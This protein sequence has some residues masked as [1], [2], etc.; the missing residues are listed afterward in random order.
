MRRHLLALIFSLAVSPA[1]A[2]GAAT[3]AAPCNALCMQR[4]QDSHALAA[5]GQYKE[6]LDTLEVARKD[7]P[8][9]S[10]PLSTA[11]FMLRD[12][13]TRVPPEQVDEL[14]KKARGLA[15]RAL[16]LDPDDALAQEAL[17]HLDNEGFSALRQLTPAATKAWEEAERFFTER[18]YAEALA[19]FRE[20][21][22]LD[23]ASSLPLIGAGDCYFAQQQW[24][25]AERLFRAAVEREP[26][27]AQAWR[28]LSD[29][30]AQQGKLKAAE[31]ALLSGI[32]ADPG[33]LPNWTKLARLRAAAGLPLKPLRFRRG[34]NLVFDKKGDV[35]I[36]VEQEIANQSGTPDG[37]FRMTLALSEASARVA[38]KDKDT[39]GTRMP[40]DIESSAWRDAL[41]A[42]Q[43]TDAGKKTGLT[44]PALRQ[45]QAFAKDGQL[46]AAILVLMYRESYRPAL[47]AW[48]AR[49]PDGVRQFIDRY[50]IRP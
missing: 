30:L 27:N 17:R 8:Q 16:E 6:A 21:M 9:A 18:R 19:K 33:Q 37:A 25:E 11:A 46:Q 24:G 20:A 47:E 38:N 43:Q 39:A 31:A 23:P 29:A 34:V 15:R 5:K 48:L 42:A 22:T 2:A 35:E 36:Q 44:D 3:A 26:R 41:Q 40:F 49:E 7:A 10:P 28:F 32:A 45:M 12:L 13:S 14:R 1:G 4:V 50:G